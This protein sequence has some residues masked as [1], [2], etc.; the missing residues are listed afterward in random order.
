MPTLRKYFCT[1]LL[2]LCLG[3]LACAQNTAAKKTS[4]DNRS[5]EETEHWI[6]KQLET[7]AGSS[8]EIQS[9][10]G[11]TQKS[12]KSTNKYDNIHFN[13]C[14]MLLDHN[15]RRDEMKWRVIQFSVPL[16]DLASAE[17]KLDDGNHGGDNPYRYTPKVP[18][19]FIR[20]R[21]K[22]IHWQKPK[23]FFPTDV[24][25]L[26]FGAKSSDHLDDTLNQLSAAF[27]HAH[28]LCASQAPKE[29]PTPANTSEGSG[30]Q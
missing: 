30:N 1:L 3:A 19:L 26:E 25:E 12:W 14:E 4:T 10:S 28:D 18:A 24:L 16:W 21:T 5:L 15:H 13:G 8:Y 17:V 29:T 7:Y 6:Q 20:T 23:T 27:M 2:C 11:D 9:G 22:S